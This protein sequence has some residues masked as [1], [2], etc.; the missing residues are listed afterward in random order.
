MYRDAHAK[1]TGFAP[2]FRVKGA[3]GGEG[4]ADR[5]NRRREGGTKSIS[6]RL[7]DMAAAGFERTAK[8]SIVACESV[9][10]RPRMTFPQ[11]CAIFDV[12]KDK[13]KD[14]IEASSSHARNDLLVIVAG[15]TLWR[16]L[17]GQDALAEV[18]VGPGA[19]AIGGGRGQ[20]AGAAEGKGADEG[21][22]DF[23]RHGRHPFHLVGG[24]AEGE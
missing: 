22:G 8:E 4:G 17:P 6:D 24:L 18:L 13:G 5:R 15:P 14:R 16:L 11:A 7:E 12:G 20:E 3:L 9:A 19:D 21:A 23:D 10:H 1:W 2:F